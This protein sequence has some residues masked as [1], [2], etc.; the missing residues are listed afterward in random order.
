M[1]SG[2]EGSQLHGFVWLL[3][4]NWYAVNVFIIV[5]GFVIFLLLD[6]KIE[7]YGEFICR[8]FFRLYPVFILL[9]GFSIPLSLIWGWN[10]EHSQYLSAF[11]GH[12]FSDELVWLHWRWNILWHLPMLHGLAPDPGWN[13]CTDTAF[14]GPAWSISLE[15]QFYLIAPLAYLAAISSRPLHRIGICVF[16]LYLFFGKNLLSEGLYY[17]YSIHGAFLPFQ[18]EFFCIGAVS[19]F[20]FKNWHQIRGDVIFPISACIAAFLWRPDKSIPICLW[21][22][23]LGL[24]LESTESYSRKIL[25]Q[26]FIHPIVQ[27]LGKISYSIY[28]SHIL[29][30]IVA[31]Y[32]LLKCMPGLSRLF[33]FWILLGTTTAGSILI[34]SILYHVIEIPGIRF[35]QKVASRFRKTSSSGSINVT[36]ERQL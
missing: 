7:T 4:Q 22:M 25:S 9:F 32:M 31:Q 15:W 14:L 36:I 29:V 3:G 13:K 30:M 35:G 11:R 23:F 18:V 19:Y 24:L 8:R 2:Y 12:Y 16:C 27:F 28:L 1:I 33:H 5:S 10:L 6:K 17:G 20:A 21:I 34:S 26:F